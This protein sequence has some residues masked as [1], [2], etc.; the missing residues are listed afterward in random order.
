MSD[1]VP[2]AAKKKLEAECKKIARK[3]GKTIKPGTIG[4]KAEEAVA[5]GVCKEIKSVDK[6]A[7]QFF[8]DQ[9]KKALD[10]KN[11]KPAGPGAGTLTKVK[12]KWTA[13]KPG[14]GVPSVTIPIT[15]WVIDRKLDTKAK[16][17][18]KIWADPRELE[19]SDKGVVVNFTVVNW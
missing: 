10:K 12:P 8:A 7:V 15:Q 5:K 17:S 2:P 19:K 13:K 1:L 16:V 18:V 3:V 11:K 6:K 4:K 14:S 9:L